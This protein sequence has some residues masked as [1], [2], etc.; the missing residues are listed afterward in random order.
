MKFHLFCGNIG[1]DRRRCKEDLFFWQ[2]ALTIDLILNYAIISKIKVDNTISKF[3]LSIN[4]SKKKSEYFE[5]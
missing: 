3:Q 4:C 2:L 1:H 5:N